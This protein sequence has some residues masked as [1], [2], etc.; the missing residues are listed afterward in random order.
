MRLPNQRPAAPWGQH[1]YW[2]KFSDPTDLPNAAGSTFQQSGVQVGDVAWSDSDDKL[3][4]CIDPT[5]GAAVWREIV[6]TTTSG[7]GGVETA[8][9]KDDSTQA[10]SG[11]GNVV[12]DEFF[13]LTAGTHLFVWYH[14]LINNDVNNVALT[15]TVEVTPDGGASVNA[16]QLEQQTVVPGDQVP[17]GGMDLLVMGTGAANRVRFLVTTAGNTITSGRKR[18][19]F[20]KLSPP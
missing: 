2:G 1:N 8:R 4:V 16:G 11:S 13:G 3:Y 6:T 20:Q 12:F 14:E 5:R 18:A 9:A 19:F 15:T 7:A 17:F 10:V